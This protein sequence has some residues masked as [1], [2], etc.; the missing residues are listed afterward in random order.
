MTRTV[1]YS[2]LM[3]AV[4]AVV[5]PASAQ[6]ATWKNSTDGIHAFLTFDSGATV[7]AIQQYGSKID[8]VWG[9]GGTTTKAWRKA[10]PGV[11]LSKYIPYTRDPGCPQMSGKAGP[12]CSNKT[13]PFVPGC[14]TCLPWWKANKPD[15]VLYQC[16]RKTPAWECFGGEGCRHDSVPLDLT[17]P[18]TLEYQMITVK[19]AKADGYNAIALDNYGLGNSWKACGSF[20][21]P[22]GAWVQKY[23]A[24]SPEKDPQY[25]KDVLDWTKRATESIHGVGLLVIP[26]FSS[27]EMSDENLAVGNY[28]DGILAEGG[29]ASWNP[30]PGSEWADKSPPMTTPSKFEAQLTWVRNLQQYGK[31]Y[32]S[33][34]EWGAGPV[35]ALGSIARQPLVSCKSDCVWRSGAGLRTQPIWSA[36]QHLRSRQQAN[37]TVSHGDVHDDEWWH[38][39]DLPHLHPML[40]GAQRWSWWAGTLARVRCAGWY[41]GGRAEQR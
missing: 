6:L 34:N 19:K 37:P 10:N 16:D 22:G 41:S 7:D 28:T 27:D 18:K 5:D 32:F 3:A 20:S 33:I 1:C 30:V 2:L 31:G 39:W 15:L 40:W 36:D 8:Y 11:V 14:P 13:S 25:T 21:G 17:N 38:P 24:S 26:N 35:S 12:Q 23:S 29:F 4:S 9:H